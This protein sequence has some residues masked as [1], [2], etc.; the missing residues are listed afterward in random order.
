M[1]TYIKIFA[2]ALLCSFAQATTSVKQGHETGHGGDGRAASFVSTAY[3]ILADL[4]LKPIA[5][6]DK[7]KL[8]RAILETKVRSSDKPLF[9]QVSKKQVDAINHPKS[10]PPEIVLNQSAW[11]SLND[12]FKKRRLVLHEYLNIAGL[13]DQHYQLSSLIDRAGICSRNPLMRQAI[14]KAFGGTSCDYISQEELHKLQRLEFGEIN[15]KEKMTKADLS[16]LDLNNLVVIISNWEFLDPDVWSDVTKLTSKFRSKTFKEFKKLKRLELHG[17]VSMNP[18]TLSSLPVL[19]ELVLVS[20]PEKTVVIEADTFLSLSHSP[21]RRLV[22]CDL[23]ET[24]KSNYVQIPNFVVKKGAFKGL[25]QVKEATLCLK[26]AKLDKE[27]LKDLSSLSHLWFKTDDFS[28]LNKDFFLSLAQGT[29]VGLIPSGREIPAQELAKFTGLDCR[30]G[31][32]WSKEKFH[33]HVAGKTYCLR[34]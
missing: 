26:S 12:A 2:L 7:V 9:D 30:S 23:S 13:D 11:D 1:K 33:Q 18:K 3:Q 14:E 10:N 8:E 17:L 28:T 25:S 5:N 20:G 27:L 34:I 29:R 24:V 31:W 32:D 21:L 4:N 15:S 16:G 22:L 6:I 19:E